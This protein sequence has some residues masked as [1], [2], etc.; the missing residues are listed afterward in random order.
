[1]NYHFLTI[2]LGTINYRRAA[3]RLAEEAQRTGRFKSA[4]GFSE[5]FLKTEDS[6]F[7]KLHENILHARTPGF[8]W[9]I[10][11]PQ[12]IKLCLEQIPEGDV[13][14]YV[15]AGT[16]LGNQDADLLS[17]DLILRYAE[18][19][20]LIGSNSQEFS[21]KL[22]SS[23]DLMDHCNLTVIDRNSNQFWAGF[24]MV[25]NN[26]SGNEFV[27]LW[28]T[29]LCRND[30]HFLCPK[31]ELNSEEP[32]F[33]HHMY[34]QAVFSCLMKQHQGLKIAIDQSC[35]YGPIR[36]S[37]HR[38]GFSAFENRRQ[39]KI[40]YKTISC[41]SRIKLYLERRIFRNSLAIRPIRHD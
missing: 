23:K 5:T 15:D 34:D 24:F 40:L 8:G 33:I 27:K 38:Y 28:K 37:R 7:W 1:M 16:V 19:Q 9:W 39:I 11:K 6:N 17:L 25:K 13:L 2:G 32:G 10:W 12:F 30:H 14:F 3:K 29:L 26:R 35:V 21:E 41:I 36:P 4:I 31:T 22:Y 18:D 20:D